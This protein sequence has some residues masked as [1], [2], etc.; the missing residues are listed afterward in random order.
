[1]RCGSSTCLYREINV[2]RVFYLFLWGNKC[3]LVRCGVHTLNDRELQIRFNRYSGFRV[4]GNRDLE[5]K[6]ES[7]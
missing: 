5:L 2:V 7:T 1:M 6:K 4:I 3:G